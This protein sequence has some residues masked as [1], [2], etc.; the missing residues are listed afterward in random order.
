MVCRLLP[1]HISATD[2][3]M[4]SPRFDCSGPEDGLYAGAIGRGAASPSRILSIGQNMG[5]RTRRFIC[6]SGLHL[7]R[8]ARISCISGRSVGHSYFGGSIPERAALLL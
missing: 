8:I 5:G 3:P 4:D 6:G 2:P 1:D 7:P